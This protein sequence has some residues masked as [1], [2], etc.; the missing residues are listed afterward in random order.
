MTLHASNGPSE[1]L[2]I[3]DGAPLVSYA[4]FN[5]PVGFYGFPMVLEDSALIPHAMRT[6]YRSAKKPPPGEGRLV[7]GTAASCRR[8]SCE[9]YYVG[10]H[11]APGARAQAKPAAGQDA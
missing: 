5:F 11:S 6:A 2:W 8:F 4:F 7:W 9:I 10:C 1:I 3:S